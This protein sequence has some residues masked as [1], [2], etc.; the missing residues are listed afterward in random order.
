MGRR[1]TADGFARE[2]VQLVRGRRSL[3]AAGKTVLFVREQRP[4]REGVMRSLAAFTAGL[5]LVGLAGS[6]ASAAEDGKALY[7]K[8][9][10]SCHGPSGKGDGPAAKAF[11]NKPSDLSATAKAMSEA[12]LAK[13]VKEG[14]PDLKPPHPK[15]KLTDEQIQAVAKHVKGL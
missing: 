11:K 7:D 15:S 4:R 9:C 12:D 14:K 8:H 13:F 10:A 1:L 2:V 5:L 3:R 6:V